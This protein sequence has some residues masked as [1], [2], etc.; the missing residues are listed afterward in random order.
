MSDDVEPT[1]AIAADTI[2]GSRY[3]FIKN[4]QKKEDAVQRF[5]HVSG[6]PCI[7]TILYSVATNSINNIPITTKV[8]TISTDM[9]GP[10]KFAA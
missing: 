3:R 6:F 10:R 7:K 5:Q 9:I 4:D 8:V 1:S 2:A